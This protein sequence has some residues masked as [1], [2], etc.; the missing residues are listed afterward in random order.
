M[1]LAAIKPFD[2]AHVD[3]MLE[4]PVLRGDRIGPFCLIKN[5]VADITIFPDGLARAGNVLPVMAA[6]AALG[7]EMTYVIRMSL[8]I[9]LHL[10][11]K[12]RSVDSLD[13][14]NSFLD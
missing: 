6:K 5:R 11:E 8:P 10:R 7:I 13:F 2:I 14:G 12:A 3:R 4:R 9:R 1:T